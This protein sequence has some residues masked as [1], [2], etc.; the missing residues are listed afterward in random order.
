[1][2]KIFNYEIEKKPLITHEEMIEL[3]WKPK[4]FNKQMVTIYDMAYEKDNYWVA[5][6]DRNGYQTMSIIA[7]DPTKIEWILISPEQFRITMKHP[8]RE[9]FVGVTAFI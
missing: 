7:I 9:V 4:E 8:T 2:E 3:G 5:F 1:M 6:G